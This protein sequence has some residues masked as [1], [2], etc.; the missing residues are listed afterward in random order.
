MN[1][2]LM[3]GPSKNHRAD[4][5]R[6]P[7]SKGAAFPPPIAALKNLPNW[8]EITAAQRD[9]GGCQDQ[10]PEEVR[11]HQGLYQSFKSGGP[12]STEP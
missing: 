4:G 12:G 5:E 6:E 10:L 7:S 8:E 11:V 1:V 9:I 2:C 3:E